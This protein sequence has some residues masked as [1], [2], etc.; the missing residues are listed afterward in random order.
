MQYLD[1]RNNTFYQAEE[2]CRKKEE[3]EEEE[4]LN[5]LHIRGS[6]DISPIRDKEENAAPQCQPPLRPFE[7]ILNLT[8]FVSAQFQATKA[9]HV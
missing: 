4:D 3:E 7:A 9:I 5:N 1:R 2:P 6:A 8:L